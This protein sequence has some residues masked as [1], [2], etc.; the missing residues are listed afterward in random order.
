MKRLEKEKQFRK[1]KRLR[2]MMSFILAIIFLLASAQFFVSNRLSDLGK[3]IEEENSKAAALIA[4]NRLLGEEINQKESLITLTSEAKK[5][6]FIETKSI[7]YLVP[8]IPVAMK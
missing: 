8:Q 1:H 4:E 7:Y 2:L 5:L 6:G 3:I